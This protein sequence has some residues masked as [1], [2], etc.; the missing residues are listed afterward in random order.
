[1]MLGI[2]RPSVSVAAERMRERGLVSYHR[3]T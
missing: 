1:M 2:R 3:A